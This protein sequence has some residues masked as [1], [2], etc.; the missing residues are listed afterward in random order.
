[1]KRTSVAAACLFLSACGVDPQFVKQSDVPPGAKVG[2]VPF[3]DCLI[4]SQEDCDGS[5][6]VAGSIFARIFSEEGF[7]AVLLSR[8]VGARMELSDAV[9]VDTAKEQ[10][11]AFVINGEV[12]QFYRVAPMTFRPDRAGLSVRL[13]RVDTGEVAAA[14]SDVR[15]SKTNFSSPDSMIADMAEEVRDELQ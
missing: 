15:A 9:A 6:G 4:D 1:M 12:T 14:Y 2:V 5:G 10:G 8:P 3:R 11:L 13:L 7:S